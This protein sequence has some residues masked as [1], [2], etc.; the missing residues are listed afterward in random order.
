MQG[1]TDRTT[2]NKRKPLTD[3]MRYWLQRLSDQGLLGHS[4]L[5]QSGANAVRALCD[6]GYATWLIENRSYEI[7]DSGRG[8]L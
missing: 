1:H 7:T 6:R 2:I 4:S 3:N 5:S 8:A